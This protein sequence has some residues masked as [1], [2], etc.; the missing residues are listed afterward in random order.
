MSGDEG[1]AKLGRGEGTP[2]EPP[3]SLQLMGDPGWKYDG[4]MATILSER[5]EKRPLVSSRYLEL[6]VKGLLQ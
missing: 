2:G 1:S 3:Q 5:V 6:L 4:W